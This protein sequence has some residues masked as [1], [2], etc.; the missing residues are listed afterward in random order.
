MIINEQNKKKKYIILAAVLIIVAGAIAFGVKYGLFF[1]SNGVQNQSDYVIEDVAYAGIFNHKGKFAFVSGDTSA[2]ITSLLEY[3]NP[4]Q[5]NLANIRQCFSSGRGRL[6]N[7]MSAKDCVSGFGDYDSQVVHLNTDEL[8]KY[9]N[10]ET[11]TPLFL[12]LPISTDQPVEVIYHPATILIG[13]KDSQKK[14]VLH[15]YW[16]GNNYEISYDDFDKL[17]GKMR[18][19]E[20][21]TYLVV[22]PKNLRDKLRAMSS[23]STAEYPNRTSI[24]VQAHSIFKNYALGGGAA[25]RGM[26]EMA[27]EYYTEALDDPKFEDYFPPYY[28]VMLFSKIAEVYLAQNKFDQALTNANKAVE[29]N[30]DLDKPFKDWPGYEEGGNKPG[31]VGVASSAYKV[32]GD[33]YQKQ[34]DYQRAVENYQKALDVDPGNENAKSGLQL[35]KLGLVGGIK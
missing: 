7:M 18:P 14:V 6:I 24:M 33:V 10:N 15:D 12:F 25:W 2:A 32:L 19:D 5:N 28:K 30:H 35:A 22:Q 23:R 31:N 21:N 1:Y 34:K 17:W 26:Y 11:K 9:I 4:G 20:R 3:W 13:V 29:L 8:K 27:Q 16:F